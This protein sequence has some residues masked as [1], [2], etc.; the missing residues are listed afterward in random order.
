MLSSRR[1]HFAFLLLM[2]PAMAVLGWLAAIV[3]RQAWATGSA[4]AWMMAWVLAF[5]VGLPATMLLL[6]IAGWLRTRMLRMHIIPHAG[7]KIPGTGQ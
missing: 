4:E 7:V 3:L 6:P 1:A 2:L 5:V